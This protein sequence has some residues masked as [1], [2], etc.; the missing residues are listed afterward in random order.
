M[1]WRKHELLHLLEHCAVRL[2]V[3]RPA[4]LVLNNIPLSIEFLLRHCRQQLTH[5]V[6]FEPERQSKLVRWNSLE[7]V[8]SLEP[9]GSVESSSG[10]LNKL[11]VLVRSN[12]SGTLEEHMLKQM[13][14][15]GSTRLL[16][17]RPH[18]IPEIHCRNR[19]S[20]V[21]GHRDE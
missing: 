5:S 12:V 13:G 7:V 9:R 19:R 14:K 2:I 1:R 10:S 18:V 11:K 16:V 21:L 4:A 20:V 8:R 6:S 15:A 17:R 3:D